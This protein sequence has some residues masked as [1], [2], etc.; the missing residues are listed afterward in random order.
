MVDR[1]TLIQLAAQVREHAYAPYSS[2]KVG[3]AL[4]SDDGCVHLGCNVEN[5][6]YGPSH[7]AE[8]TA[9]HRAIADGV[10]PGAFRAIAVIG[11]TA[12][13]IT[14]CGVCRQVL[15]ELCSPDMPVYMA[16]LQG[17]VQMMKVAELLPGAFSLPT[18]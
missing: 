5:A 14:P 8:R 18:G 11:D 12:R 3:A 16:N 4:L 7:C 13:P 6:A 10:K 2:F 15:S 1:D 9:L 17:E